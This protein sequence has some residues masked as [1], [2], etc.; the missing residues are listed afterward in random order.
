MTEFSNQALGTPGNKTID[1]IFKE[2][3]EETIDEIEAHIRKHFQD[4]KNNKN[5]HSLY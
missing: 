3:I 5:K 4:H 2:T 1:E